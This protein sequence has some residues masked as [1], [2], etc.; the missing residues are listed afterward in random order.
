MIKKAAA[1]KLLLLAALLSMVLLWAPAAYASAAKA[2]IFITSASL[3]ATRVAP[4]DPVAVIAEVANTGTAD[5]SAQINLYVNDYD[6]ADQSVTLPSGSKTSIKFTVSCVEPGI[7]TVYV[8]NAP[9]GSFTVESFAD[10]KRIL[11]ISGAL[12]FFLLMSGAVYLLRK[13]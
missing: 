1:S 4:R 12:I 13:K 8:G 5:G 9:A 3:S 7:Y 2:N 11:Y 6:V 10:P